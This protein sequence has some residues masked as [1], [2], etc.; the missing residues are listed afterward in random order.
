MIKK[1]VVAD[2]VEAAF[3]V[4]LQNPFGGMLAV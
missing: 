4:S 3:N 2:M 1:P